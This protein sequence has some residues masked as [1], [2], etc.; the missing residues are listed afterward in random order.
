VGV[1]VIALTPAIQF[2]QQFSLPSGKLLYQVN[3]V[4]YLQKLQ[5]ETFDI[6]IIGAGASGAGCALDAVLRGF[7][8]ALIE[9]DDF[10]AATSSKST[11]LIHGG[12]R[13]LEQAVSNFDLAQLKQVR[14]GLEERHTV[15][16]NAPFLARPLPLLTPC[17]TWMEGCYYAVGLRVYD[18]FAKEDTLPKSRW[19]SKQEV[20]Q[21]ASGLR[22]DIHSAVLYYDGQLDDAR[23]CMLLAKTAAEKGATLA[24][25]LPL[26]GFE[27][28]EAGKLIAAQVLDELSGA[29][30][31][32]RARLFLNCTGAHADFVRQAANPELA[33]RIIPSKGVHAVL[34]LKS[35]GTQDTALLIPKT[36]DGRVIF[37]IPWEDK[38]LL[39]TTDTPYSGEEEPVLE[40][41]ETEFLIE[42]LNRYLADPIGPEQITAGFGGLRPL[43]ASDPNRS[44]KA[45]VRDHEVERDEQSS[46]LSLLGGKW[47]TYRLMAADAI[48]EACQQLGEER[49][50]LTA[51]QLLAGAEGYDPHA[52]QGWSKASNLSADICEHLSNKYGTRATAI[53][54]LLKENPEWSERLH[55][56]YPFI[57]A[58]VIYQ[59][60]E[61]MAMRPRDVLARRLRL[62]VLDWAATLDLTPVVTGLLGQ[63]LGWTEQECQSIAAAYQQ[64]VRHFQQSASVT[65]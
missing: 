14:H 60:R 20:M 47:T 51:N 3:R 65:V 24:N 31:P 5:T 46:L 42:N 15:I 12:V 27:K 54:N 59:A 35:L 34:P 7:K 9:K 17:Y 28:D 58:E 57:Q 63:E 30:F 61:E 18:A 32:V 33:A 21:R 40:K 2:F 50:C 45:L 6:C 1:S 56:H 25:H 55:A 19:I 29:T 38:L 53:L 22:P 43:I 4:Q 48:D 36:T 10:A 37:A 64:Q 39:G 49:P 52:W 26:L 8:V 44:T 41:A 23:Y 11:K 13:Y 62:E 16:Q